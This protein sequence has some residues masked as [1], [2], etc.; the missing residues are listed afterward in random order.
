MNVDK[1]GVMHMRHTRKKDV[2][3]SGQ[4]FGMNGEGIANV[5][6]YRYLGCIIKSACGKQ[7]NG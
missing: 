5:A 3:R 2:K 4:R 7:D 1:C 6:E